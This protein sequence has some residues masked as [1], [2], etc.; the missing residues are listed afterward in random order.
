[1]VY[2]PLS[3]KSSTSN[4]L[5]KASSKNLSDSHK[6]GPTV[7]KVKSTN[8]TSSAASHKDAV[9]ERLSASHEPTVKVE[10]QESFLQANR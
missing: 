3:N 2:T 10:S 6:L 7:V 1:M 4:S 5:S 9:V 8:K